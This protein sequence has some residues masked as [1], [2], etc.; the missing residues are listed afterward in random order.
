MLLPDGKSVKLLDFGT[1]CDLGKTAK[2]R[3]AAKTRVYTEGYAPPEQI[4]GRPEPRSDLF[5]L[6]A[7]M[8]HLVTGQAPEGYFTAR[9]IEAKLAEPGAIP[10]GQRWFYELIRTN[11]AEDVE[12]RYH[13]AGE[14][15]A[16]L[17]KRAITREANCPGCG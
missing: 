6:A 13:T 9:E 2:E 17:E 11:L 14:I 12:E 1:A 16:D 10:N 5:A 15:K 7:T 4:V 8:Y 3:M